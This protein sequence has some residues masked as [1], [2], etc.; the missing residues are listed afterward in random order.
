MSQGFSPHWLYPGTKFWRHKNLES[1][2]ML[3]ERAGTATYKKEQTVVCSLT[4]RLQITYI[5]KV[6]R[7]DFNAARIYQ[8]Q[9]K[10]EGE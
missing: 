1:S 10:A 5:W 9:G 8:S 7:G 6:T 4:M 2:S 3:N